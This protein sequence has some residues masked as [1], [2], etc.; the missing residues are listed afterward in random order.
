MPAWEPEDRAAAIVGSTGRRAS[1]S[2]EGEA[3]EDH[4]RALM[5]WFVGLTP[6]QRL[7]ALQQFVDD[8]VKLRGRVA[9]PLR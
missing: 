2:L 7:D 6:Q 3:S 5:R 1:G 9:G 8:I 4:D